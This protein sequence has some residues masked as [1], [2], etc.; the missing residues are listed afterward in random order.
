M[1][2]NHT[3]IPPKPARRSIVLVLQLLGFL[4]GL[5][6]LAWCGKI[7]FSGENRD[8]L[9]QLGEAPPLLMVSLI[10]LSGL[11]VM[12]DG[13]TIWL[14]L[15]PVRRIQLSGMLATNA[16]ATFL[17]LLPFKLSVMARI[18][19][20]RKRDG[21]PLAII[22]PWFAAVGAVLIASVAPVLLLAAWRPEIDLLWFVLL[23][24]S[25][26]LSAAGLSI[27]AYAFSGKRGLR[28]IQSCA[29]R[30]PIGLIT[31]I[32]HS[33][34]FSLL[35]EGLAMLANFKNTLAAIGLRVAYIASIAA[36]FFIAS[37]IVGSPMPADQSLVGSVSYFFI[38]IVSPIGAL[39]A[40]ERGAAEILEWFGQFDLN[41]L[42]LIVVVVTG[43]ELLA[44]T[45]LAA[46]GIAWLRPD[47]LIRGT[48]DLSSTD[49]NRTGQPEPDRR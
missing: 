11:G 30:Q 24:A 42:L 26:A 5:A 19:I 20:H 3:P 31:N 22:G 4:I 12:L 48:G 25:L 21:V 6:L 40:R 1:T 23:T 10:L 15:R 9:K 41:Q 7:A 35:D 45:A 37:R 18:A 34:T 43:A 38:G 27:S 36:R 32:A 46:V 16:L 28:I 2:R 49:D 8:A 14:V 47:R 17:S 29:K 13:L 44:N 39:G 33:E